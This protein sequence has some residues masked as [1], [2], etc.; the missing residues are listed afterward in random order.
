MVLP[1]TSGD[2]EIAQAQP[3][4]IER[5]IS[6]PKLNTRTTEDQ[7][8]TIARSC[9]TKEKDCKEKDDVVTC[10]DAWHCYSAWTVIDI[11]ARFTVQGVPVLCDVT[12]A[13]PLEGV[14]SVSFLF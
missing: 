4:G 11:P 3:K 12:R 1:T 2:A 6:A 14:R 5:K 8:S 10:E 9:R 13:F 7:R